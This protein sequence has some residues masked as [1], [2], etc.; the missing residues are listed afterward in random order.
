MTLSVEW[1]EWKQRLVKKV[2]T[3]FV[4]SKAKGI[5]PFCSV[6]INLDSFSNFAS[7][8]EY[9]LSGLCQRCQDNFFKGDE[10]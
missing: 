8:K 4:E 3:E 2:F 7:L 6:T 1:P 10:K 5:C 9:S